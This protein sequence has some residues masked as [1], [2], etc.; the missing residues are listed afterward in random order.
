M[1]TKLMFLVAIT[2]STMAFGQSQTQ[3][4]SQN[5]L[6]A[7]LSISPPEFS[8]GE[9]IWQDH[10]I[11]SINNYLE[12]FVLYPGGSSNERRIGTEVVQFTV[13]HNGEVGDF[14]IIN[15]IS[16]DIDNEV[17]RVLSTT[18]GMW[19]PGTINGKAIAME[20]EV[21]LVFKPHGNYDMFGAAKEYQ[22][23]GNN[24]LFVQ[25]NPKRALKY[26]NKA[27][28][29]LP[30]EESILAARSLCKYE[31]GDKEGA[32]QDYTRVM[33][34]NNPGIIMLKQINQ[35]EVLEQLMLYA[36]KRQ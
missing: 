27:F 3:K 2:L 36:Q 33:A 5:K 25:K 17:I 19:K 35:D 26:F 18:G 11:G 22:D 20:R 4:S 29:L 34:L 23:K 10:E 14:H 24:M 31:L 7:E 12:A 16:S 21:S 30:S 8:I 32:I 6:L 15:S 28:N 1:K 13:N 9:P